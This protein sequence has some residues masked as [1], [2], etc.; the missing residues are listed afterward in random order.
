MIFI[1]T[2][3]KFIVIFKKSVKKITLKKLEIYLDNN[4]RMSHD[5]YHDMFHVKPKQRRPK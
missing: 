2:L 3:I 1:M 4:H 5:L